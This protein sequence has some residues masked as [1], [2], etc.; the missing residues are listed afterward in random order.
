MGLHMAWP[1]AH[2]VGV[3]I[4]PQ[5]RYPFDFVQ[6]D[7]RKLPLELEDFDFIWSSPPCQAFS[8]ASLPQRRAGVAYHDLITLTRSMLATVDA[9]TVI[10]NVPKAPIRPD[11][12]LD[13]TMFPTLRV[14]R[15]RIFELNFPAPLT[16]GFNARGHVT[17]QGWSSVTGHDVS[18][19]I[20]AR[21]K[22]MGLPERD[23]YED[24]RRAMGIHWMNIDELSE[25]IPPAYSE[26]IARAADF[27][28]R[29]SS[30]V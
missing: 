8:D 25:A 24:R 9:P 18:S 2:I 16:L 30:L 6:A 10:E 23:S 28:A 4:K 1:E 22:K 17:C 20:R 29:P 12:V 13:G 7:V 19:H 27:I 15:K 14:I 3:D 21:R 26:Y 5:P 11:L